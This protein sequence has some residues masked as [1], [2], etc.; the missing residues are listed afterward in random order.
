MSLLKQ[1]VK[2][3]CNKLV[4]VLAYSA[5]VGPVSADIQIA[6]MKMDQIK[7]GPAMVRAGS[8]L[9]PHT[10][11]MFAQQIVR[12]SSRKGPLS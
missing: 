2:V 11:N 1:K 9:R 8:I 3:G 4:R 6:A 10:P 5:S 12:N 7:L